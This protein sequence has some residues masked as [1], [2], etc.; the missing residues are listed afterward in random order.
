M[1][2]IDV[3]EKILFRVE[4]HVFVGEEFESKV[5]TNSHK[6]SRFVSQNI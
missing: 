3:D 6:L 1:V 2:S 4:G 5:Y